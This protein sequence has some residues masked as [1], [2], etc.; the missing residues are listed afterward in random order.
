MVRQAL[1][2]LAVA[3]GVLCAAGNLAFAQTTVVQAPDGGTSTV[4]VQSD[5]SGNTLM[6]RQGVAV[7]A[8]PGQGGG[9][10]QLV[11]GVNTD[12]GAQGGGVTSGPVPVQMPS[13]FGVPP[14]DQVMEKGSSRIRGRVTAADSGRPLRRALVRL[15]SQGA[16]GARSTTTDADGRYEFVDLPAAQYQISASRSG[17]VQLGYRQPRPNS[18]PRPFAVGENQT[19]DRIDIALP[20]GGVIT[21]RVVDEYG[22]PVSDTF[23]SA[24]RQQFINGVRRPIPTGAPSSSNDIGE[25]RI[26]GLAPGDYY[27]SAMPRGGALNPFDV[28]TDNT[29]YAQTFYP[30][31]AD[32][33][34]AQRVTV[35]AGDTVSNIVVTLTP[36]RMA[37]ISGT[38]LDSQG[39][40]AKGG[41]VMV[42]PASGMMG[43]PLTPGMVAPDGSFTIS[44][45]PPGSYTL[46]ST[47]A[48]PV[49]GPQAMSSLAMA[50]I[51]VNG[52]DISNVIVQPVAPITITGRLTGDPV[53]LAQVKPSS[54]RLMAAPFGGQVTLGGPLAPP[55]PLRDDLS[56]ELTVQPGEYFI[57]P[58][59]LAGMVIRSVRLAGLDVTRGFRIE[60]GAAPN[61]M[62]VEVTSS[63][64]SLVVTAANAREEAVADRDIVVFPQDE[65]QW[66]TQMPG[67]GSTG[68]TDEQG[69]YQSPPLLPGAYYVAATEGLEAGMS[70]DPDI[71]QSLR[72]G[73][74]RITLGD[75]ET[76]NLQFRIAER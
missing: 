52:S 21:G 44:A 61:D 43:L 49:A 33:A 13:G 30:S 1:G 31:T 54:T 68:R 38:V 75:G 47:P 58:L 20:P 2:C 26:H 5:G 37:R 53:T 35:R 39:Q 59:T 63:T 60:A 48:G 66:G 64:A 19:L 41:V 6:I 55:Q 4:T 25:F 9:Q 11:I 70:A 12:Q 50:T 71:L 46:R 72:V 17:Y 69:R 76:A 22:D 27:I 56:F 18:A 45:V 10:Q 36:A 3:G 62:E 67:H 14:R 28:S 74:Q 34:A 51:T 65:T 73:A 24:Q 32:M 23:V 42:M 15:S 7:D 8:P 29:G 57:R 16:R 40:P